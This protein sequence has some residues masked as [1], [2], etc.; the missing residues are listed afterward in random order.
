M[1]TAI[2]IMVVLCLW[3]ILSP[4][5]SD[6]QDPLQQVINEQGSENGLNPL[7]A[8]LGV[9]VIF[10]AIG[11]FPTP[12]KHFVKKDSCSDSM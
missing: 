10:H 4:M 11:Y 8:A 3:F 6:L 12:K 2:F 9:F 7:I 1:K 5:G